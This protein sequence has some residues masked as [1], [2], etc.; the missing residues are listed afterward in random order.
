MMSVQ[1]GDDDE[2]TGNWYGGVFVRAK[3]EHAAD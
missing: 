3:L 1:F 2:R